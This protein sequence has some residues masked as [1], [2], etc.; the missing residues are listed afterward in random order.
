MYEIYDSVSSQGKLSQLPTSPGHFS[1]FSYN[2]EAPYVDHPEH[3]E[4]KAKDW[5]VLSSG[6]H[7]ASHPVSCCA[8][9]AYNNGLGIFRR[10]FCFPEKGSGQDAYGHSQAVPDT[11][12]KVHL[13]LNAYLGNICESLPKQSQP[14]AA[15]V[16]QKTSVTK[17]LSCF[18][19]RRPSITY[20]LQS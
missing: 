6:P 8:C 2:P 4:E 11:P 17:I 20:H 12:Y 5:S 18:R 19:H 7:I 3:A 15:Y 14:L 16:S 9:Q 10:L 1:H 13:Y